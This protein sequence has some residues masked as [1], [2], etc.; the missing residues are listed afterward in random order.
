MPNLYD[1]S[2]EVQMLGFFLNDAKN[3]DDYYEKLSVEDDFYDS[4]IRF[5]YKVVTDCYFE[6]G[7]ITKEALNVYV[8]KQKPSVKDKFRE[9]GGY[10]TL[11]EIKGFTADASH[12]IEK[13]FDTLKTYYVF[14]ELADH[15]VEI[16]PLVD[17]LKDKPPQVILDSFDNMINNISINLCG[18]HEPENLSVGTEK[19]LKNLEVSPDIGID[20]PFP[21][22]NSYLRGLRKG[23]ATCIAAHTNR[24]KTRIITDILSHISVIGDYKTLFISTEQT[25]TEMKLQF[26]T[27]IY[28]QVICQDPSNRIDER[29]IATQDITETQKQGL[30]EAAE[31]FEENCK[32][33]FLCTNMYDLKTLE[34]L[35]KRAELKGCDVVII[36]VLKPMRSKKMNTNLAEWQVYSH[37]VERLRDLAIEFGLAVLFTAQ[38]KPGTEDKTELTISDL[39]L[40]THIAFVL[41]ACLIFRDIG[42]E[43][44]PKVS[45]QPQGD[46]QRYPLEEGNRYMSCKIAKNRAGMNGI[47]IAFRAR[48]GFVKFTELGILHKKT[49]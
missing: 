40:G 23:T 28:N 49:A 36:D 1:N 12:N 35:I 19:F 20:I 24:G 27:N 26:L 45:Y 44:I 14:R 2:A 6:T 16:E 25:E 22:L 4:T 42:Y 10:E 3:I 46:T 41:D 13:T 47:Q 34:R 15:K 17:E 32:I 43:E 30:Y 9:A 37:T 39:A 33:D 11:E 18:V 8:D 31:Y 38:L 21:M 48:H 29:Q 5:F 7:L